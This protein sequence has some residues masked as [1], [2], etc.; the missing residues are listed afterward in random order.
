M[1]MY[2]YIYVLLSGLWVQGRE[3][4]GRKVL[5]QEQRDFVLQRFV[6]SETCHEISIAI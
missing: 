2:V 6:F 4:I 5:V 1:G 3:S